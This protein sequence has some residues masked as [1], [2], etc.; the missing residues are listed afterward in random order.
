MFSCAVLS[1]GSIK[2][3]RIPEKLFLYCMSKG[4]KERKLLRKH[5][6]AVVTAEI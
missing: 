2:W 5:S 4:R 1:P 6:I 3:A